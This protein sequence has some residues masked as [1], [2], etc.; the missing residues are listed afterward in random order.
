MGCAGGVNDFKACFSK[1]IGRKD[2]NMDKKRN[3]V[4]DAVKGL[5]I[6]TVVLY[7]FGKILPY[8]F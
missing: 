8:G 3:A 5:A 6:L 4:I 1:L 2:F 7:H